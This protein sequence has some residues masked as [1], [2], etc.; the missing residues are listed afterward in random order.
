MQTKWS[1]ETENIIKQVISILDPQNLPHQT[2]NIKN[3]LDIPEDKAKQ[4][5]DSI[6]Q[7]IGGLYGSSTTKR[8]TCEV[9]S[10]LGYHYT[11]IAVYTIKSD[12]TEAYEKLS[13]ERRI[14]GENFCANIYDVYY[15][16]HKAP[17]IDDDFET[18]AKRIISRLNEDDSKNR[19]TVGGSLKADAKACFERISKERYDSQHHTIA[20]K[21]S[22]IFVGSDGLEYVFIAERTDD[23]GGSEWYVSGSLKIECTAIGLDKLLYS[24]SYYS[25]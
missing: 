20:S 25:R 21:G 18:L 24:Y 1:N 13:I 12:R 16:K 14:P 3:V 15:K 11:F 7:T 2:Y 23:C 17:P 4:I 22:R 10:A 8:G 19:W 6:P 5:Y 9:V